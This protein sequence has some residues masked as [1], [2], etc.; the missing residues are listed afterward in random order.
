MKDLTNQPEEGMI[1][2]SNMEEWEIF[3]LAS[4]LGLTFT[5][6]RIEKLGGHLNRTQNL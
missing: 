3:S 2:S 6:L 1:C 5:D 4:K